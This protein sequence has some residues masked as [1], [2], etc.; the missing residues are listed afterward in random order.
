M[1]LWTG[2]KIY[3]FI[4]TELP[5]TEELITRVEDVGKEDKQ[6]L[7]G[8]GPIFEWIPGN[9]ILDHQEEKEFIDDLINDI[10]YQHNDDNDS[11]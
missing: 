1:Y 9:I 6:P 8:N 3:G 2:R 4:W 5:I 11:D 7:M 10:Q